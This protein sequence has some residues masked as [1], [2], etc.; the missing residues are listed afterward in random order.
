MSTVEVIALKPFVYSVDGY[1]EI[2]VTEKEVFNLPE[3]FFDGLNDARYVRR[4]TIGDG[5][6]SLTPSKEEIAEKVAP[7]VDTAMKLKEV[8]TEVAETKVDASD[9]EIP[10]DWKSLKFFALRSIASKISDS[11]IKN[12]EDAIAAIE[13]ELARRG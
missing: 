10:D 7:I 5:R 8:L 2:P 12:M 13:A 6:V 11:P 4:A 3:K 1:T 9:V